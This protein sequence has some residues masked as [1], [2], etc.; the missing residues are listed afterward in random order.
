YL[1]TEKVQVGKGRVEIFDLGEATEKANEA[2]LSDYP[3]IGSK[4][5]VKGCGKYYDIPCDL[6]DISGGYLMELD[7]EARYDSLSS[8]Y[9]TERGQIISIKSP[10][11]LSKAQFDYIS[12][13]LQQM[14]NALFSEDG[15]DPATGKR[16]EDIVDLDSAVRKYILE[17]LVCNFDANKTSQFF[18]KAPDR[19]DPKIYFGPAWD[20][21]MSLGNRSEQDG[22]QFIDPEALAVGVQVRMKLPVYYQALYRLLVVRDR[23][24]ALYREANVL[25][26]A[27]ALALGN[28]PGTISIDQW[29]ERIS[30]SVR[31][32]YNINPHRYFAPYTKAFGADVQKH[33]D[34]VKDFLLRRAR[35]LDAL[36]CGGQNQ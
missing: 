21:D 13:L 7:L 1:L 28:D 26:A 14:E 11:Y 24:S 30:S 23:L 19:V 8:A 4:T 3:M 35:Y 36:W 20:Y 6:E 25:K 10:K 22:V 15:V 12:A 29:S 18:Y 31:K 16:F 5:V 17:E 9:V 33:V 32:N 34:S 27:E 2:P